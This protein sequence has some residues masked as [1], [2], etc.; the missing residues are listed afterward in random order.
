MT[1]YVCLACSVEL[2]WS[3]CS[4]LNL[5]IDCLTSFFLYTLSWQR[6]PSHWTDCQALGVHVNQLSS[7]KSTITGEALRITG[8]SYLS[9]DSPETSSL[10]DMLSA[11]SSFENLLNL[12]FVM[13]TITLSISAVFW[14]VG[15]PWIAMALL[16]GWGA[17]TRKLERSR[18]GKKAAR[19]RG[20]CV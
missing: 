9:Y 4:H 15:L 19:Q 6:S 12:L 2:E 8:E 5:C 7:F 13:F 18:Q 17:E 20:P 1:T 16:F 11:P 10:W 3:H 14:G